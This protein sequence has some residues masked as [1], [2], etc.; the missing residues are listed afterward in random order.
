MLFLKIKSTDEC[1]VS[2]EC[3]I[4][5]AT[6][7][8]LAVRFI[9]NSTSILAI[10]GNKELLAGMSRWRDSGLHTHVGTGKRVR[11]SVDAESGGGGGNSIEF[12]ATRLNA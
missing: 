11:R 10:Y 3:V 8:E 7:M 2:A 9:E 12:E 6:R 5:I 1:V 4:Y